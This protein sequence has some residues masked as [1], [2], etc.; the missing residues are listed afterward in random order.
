MREDVRLEK[1][2]L[3]IFCVECDFSR[4]E[5][6]ERFHVLVHFV[7][8]A[9]FQFGTLPSQLLRVER[10]V[11]ETSCTRADAGEIGHPSGTAKFATAWTDTA[12]ASS[13][14]ACT[15]LFHF[16]A[17]A[18]TFCQHLDELTEIHAL[19]CN[20]VENRL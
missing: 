16:D 2:I 13:L 5:T 7:V 6:L 20:V 17:Y 18:E 11:L 1:E 14:L 3:S 9:A 8:E 15:N 12:D 10:N 19:I 4:W